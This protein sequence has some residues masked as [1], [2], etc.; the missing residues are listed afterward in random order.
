MSV[1]TNKE[2]LPEGYREWALYAL[3]WVERHASVPKTIL[4][5]TDLPA[6]QTAKFG[7]ATVLPAAPFGYVLD[8][9]HRASVC[10][11]TPAWGSFPMEASLEGCVPI[12]WWGDPFLEPLYRAAGET[13][14]LLDP[15]R[16]SRAALEAALDV[17]LYDTAVRERL[18]EAARELLKPYSP[19][20]TLACFERIVQEIG[21]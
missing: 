5:A 14:L 10:L 18:V 11:N 21:L 15:A 16:P 1:P 17:L 19:E 7:H 6:G 20:N 9:M 8:F 3:E 12:G 13:H 2:G 4:C